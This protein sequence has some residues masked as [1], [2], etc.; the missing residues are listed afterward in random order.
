MRAIV[1][2]QRIFL[3]LYLL[4][5][6]TGAAVLWQFE[7]GNEI[8]YADTLHAPLPD[9]FFRYITKL[10]EAPFIILF[11][12]LLAAYNWR[13]AL[14]L[15]ANL[16]LASGLTQFLKRVVFNGEVR[17]AL[18]FQ[19]KAELSFVPGVEVFHY[20]SFPS[21]HTT[22][23]FALFF[24]LSLLFP[25]RWRQAFFFLGALLVGVSRV[26]LL[27]HFFRDVYAGALVGT[28]VPLV[29]FI[30]FSRYIRVSDK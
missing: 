24:T 9:V 28:V 10:V 1:L 27:Q 11:P 16:M 19:G 22:A 13:M 5:L 15:G 25:G 12:V 17:P 8:L 29:V 26:Y 2:Q 6:L 4:F 14:L 21:G 3:S 18:Y 23:A 7:K 20:H 30:L